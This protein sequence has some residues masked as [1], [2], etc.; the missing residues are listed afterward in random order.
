MPAR[1]RFVALVCLCLALSPAMNGCFDASPVSP[2]DG[3]GLDAGT[4]DWARCSGFGSCGLQPA[5]CCDVCGEPTSMDVDA[6]RIGA[7]PESAH[8]AEVCDTPMPTCPACATA[9]NPA[10][11]P[12]CLSNR[13]TVFDVRAQPISACTSN[14]DCTLVT[15]A[16]CDCAGPYISVRA[17]AQTAF[18]TAVCD[19]NDTCMACGS[20]PPSNLEAF[21]A[22]D[23]HCDVRDTP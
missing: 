15:S 19:P 16:C 12:L 4:P 2:T 22:P 23:G 3:G 18:R 17:D 14:T 13:C 10:L 1:Y 5:Q 7:S 11:Y 9:P 21:C 6:V 8:Q 20:P